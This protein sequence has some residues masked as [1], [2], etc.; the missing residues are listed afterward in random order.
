MKKHRFNID[1][2]APALCKYNIVGG[3]LFG[4]A[5]NGEVSDGSD[6]DIAVLFPDKP[7][8][9]ELTECRALLQQALNFDDIDLIVLN[10]A[11]VIL[12][13]QAL[14]GKRVLCADDARCAEF[15]SLTARIYEDEMAQCYR[16]L[17][18]A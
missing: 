10:G 14:L 5:V 11:S 18:A 17:H 7:G 4:S 9:D 8:L 3:W 6:I 2:I 16:A 12:Q 1:E 13:F 15:A